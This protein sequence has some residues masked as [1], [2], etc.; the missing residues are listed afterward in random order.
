MG[1]CPSFVFHLSYTATR[2]TV[3]CLLGHVLNIKPHT[4]AGR[5]QFDLRGTEG[6]QGRSAVHK[7]L[8]THEEHTRGYE[9]LVG[10]AGST[11]KVR[12][13][14]SSAVSSDVI[15]ANAEHF[16]GSQVWKAGSQRLRTLW[17]DVIVTHQQ[18]LQG[19]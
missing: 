9:G 12:D 10:G 4:Q 16:K 7:G 11:L 13:K 17:S 5:P 3:S 8:Q 18:R 2:I 1:S 6:I 15:P 19:C 14:G